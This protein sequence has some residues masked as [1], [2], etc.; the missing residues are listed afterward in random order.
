M[1]LLHYPRNRNDSTILLASSC[2]TSYKFVRSLR[3]HS[4]PSGSP[5]AS[6]SQPA[7]ILPT[8]RILAGTATV[9]MLFIRTLIIIILMLMMKVTPMMM[10]IMTVM[11]TMIIAVVVI[12]VFSIC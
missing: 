12:I 6:T 10:V 1:F 8:L 4:S 9:R 2:Q 5:P 3:P 11:M 7:A